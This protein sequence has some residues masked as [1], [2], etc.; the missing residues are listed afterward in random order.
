[1]SRLDYVTL[2]SSDVVEVGESTM[3]ITLRKYRNEERFGTD[4]HKVCDFL[5]RINKDIV[6]KPNF[7]W[8][9]WVWMIS[10]PVDNEEQR[11]L[12]GIWEDGEKIVALTTYEL[13][14][15]EIH[16]CIDPPYRFLIPEII[17]YAEQYLSASGRLRII[18]PDSDREFQRKAMEKGYRP[19]EENEPVAVLDITEDLNYD[20][21]AGYKII[22]MAEE[23]D[24]C[25][26]NR[27][28][29]R[30]FGHDR[31]PSQDREDIEWR[32]TMLSSPHLTPELVIAVKEPGGNYAS[33]C[34]LWY[35]PGSEYAYVEPLATDPTYRKMGLGKAALLEAII[36]ARKMGAKEVFVCSE[37]QF[38]YNIGFYPLPAETCW[39]KKLSK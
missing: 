4:Y 22:S 24:F 5:V 16:I 25:K 17:A 18:I 12:I 14:F 36:R 29:W 39:E 33:H 20:L 2:R 1:M 35:L 3:N 7:L 21:P 31:E 8:G 10:R 30:G 32:E 27:V 11:N 37:Q 38:Y 9:R 26:Y 19:L 13:T 28:M 15:G 6:T 34:G 23:W